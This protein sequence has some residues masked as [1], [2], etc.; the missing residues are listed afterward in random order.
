MSDFELDSSMPCIAERLCRSLI[1]SVQPFG[2]LLIEHLSAAAS[3]HH[4]LAFG[5]RVSHDA[6]TL[7][8][9]PSGRWR[10]VVRKFVCCCMKY[11]SAELPP[12]AE[13][14]L[15]QKPKG[16]KKT[17]LGSPE[18]GAEGLRIST[19]NSR[20]S[21]SGAVAV[22]LRLRGIPTVNS[23]NHSA[24]RIWYPPALNEPNAKLL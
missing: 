3:C 7:R 9:R 5:L 22:R 20:F 14:C 4:P 13:T 2:F 18:R 16:C 12:T 23:L 21:F 15:R 24:F 11:N 17:K 10:S 8:Y 6:V 19:K 1:R